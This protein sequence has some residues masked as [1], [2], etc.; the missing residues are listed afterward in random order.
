M[1]G[2][3]SVVV[4]RELLKP[5]DGS[6]LNAAADAVAEVKRMRKLL[7]EM[8]AVE[9]HSVANIDDCKAEKLCGKRFNEKKFYEFTNTED[10]ISWVDL[11]TKVAA[12]LVP[13]NG[14]VPLGTYMNPQMPLDDE[15][16]NWGNTNVPPTKLQQQV[17]VLLQGRWAAPR[18]I[19]T[20]DEIDPV[21]RDL[22]LRQ[23]G[24]PPF[25]AV[26]WRTLEK[27]GRFPN[28]D[29]GESKT[30]PQI[31]VEMGERECTAPPHPPSATPF[32]RPPP[33]KVPQGFWPFFDAQCADVPRLQLY[34]VSHRWLRSGA[35]PAHPDDEAGS[36]A[37]MLAEFGKALAADVLGLEAY[38][39]IDYSCLNWTDRTRGMIALPLYISM[40]TAGLIALNHA[41]YASRG[42]CRLEEAVYCALAPTPQ[43]KNLPPIPPEAPT[44]ARE[45]EQGETSA[46]V[47]NKRV[48]TNPLEGE[49]SVEAD[50]QTAQ[51]LMETAE[52]LWGHN[53]LKKNFDET[54]L[55]SS[56]S[57]QYGQTEV[58]LV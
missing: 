41:E 47:A 53:W 9:E 11:S 7:H 39:W 16:T 3:A 8:R 4:E 50:R 29:E 43:I 10:K 36:K 55:Q 19:G 23:I 31:M 58:F 26:S 57:L 25:R 40:C 34:M 37:R 49:F 35:D 44:S 30:L 38:F 1:G 48:L 52:K 46:T 20:R 42:W 6:D 21:H 18:L 17:D 27:L 22:L 33:A 14:K 28:F 24:C 54:K 13:G 15:G 56:S 32:G 51:K 5:V 45:K 2:S 12:K